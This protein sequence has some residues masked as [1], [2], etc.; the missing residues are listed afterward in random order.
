MKIG[1]I[2][3]GR[4]GSAIA[5]R[6]KDAG[7]DLVVYDSSPGTTKPFAAAGVT[8]AGDVGDCR[9]TPHS[10][11]SRSVRGGSAIRCRRAAST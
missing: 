2:G 7:M 1:F 3:V 8:V 10:R 9:T 6:L 11:R 5:G 4:M